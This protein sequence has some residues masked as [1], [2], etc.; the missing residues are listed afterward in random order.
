MVVSSVNPF[1][2]GMLRKFRPG[3]TAIVGGPVVSFNAVGVLSNDEP[4]VGEY[5]AKGDG[6]G[7]AVLQMSSIKHSAF[8]RALQHAPTLSKKFESDGKLNPLLQIELP[9]ASVMSQLRSLHVV[10]EG[11]GAS[12]S[13]SHTSMYSQFPLTEEPMPKFAS[14][15][16]MTVPVTE[17][18]KIVSF[19]VIFIFNFV[20]PAQGCWL[21]VR[22]AISDVNGVGTS[23]T[24]KKED[25]LLAGRRCGRHRV[26]SRGRR[27]R[28]KSGR[29]SWFGRCHGSRIRRRVTD[30]DNV[31]IA[32]YTAVNAATGHSSS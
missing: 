8:P 16:A 20:A 19:H 7:L 23:T 26:G 6:V 17:R 30:I 10:G 18:D 1:E 22:R 3:L 9:P 5:V 28:L 21:T 14:Q 29:R 24:V 12:V 27:H 25:H 13:R 2:S 15:Q 31:A 4:A 11:V 32:A